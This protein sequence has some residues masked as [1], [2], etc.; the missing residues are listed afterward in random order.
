VTEADWNGCTD[1]DLM[2]DFLHGKASSRK[3]RLFA[4]GCCRMVQ[5][6]FKD[7]H[8][9]HALEVAERLADEVVTQNEVDEAE[10]QAWAAGDSWPT[11]MVW[12]A[13]QEAWPEPAAWATWALW[14][15]S[16]KEAPEIAASLLRDLFGSL[17][18]RPITLAPSC[19]TPAVLALAHAAYNDHLLPCGHLDPAHLGVLA[20]ALADA[21][22]TDALLLEHLRRVGPHVRGCWALDLVLGR[23]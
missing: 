17:P 7:R 22:C 8:S 4:C 23:A 21:G 14:A 16:Q 20:Q 6:L 15:A 2:L 10:G 1:P 19:L 12:E 11:R 3:M 5:D 18:F 9:L 13:V